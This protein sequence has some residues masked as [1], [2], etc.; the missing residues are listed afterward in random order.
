MDSSPSPECKDKDDYINDSTQRPPFNQYH[1]YNFGEATGNTVGTTIQAILLLL[2][3]ILVWLSGILAWDWELGQLSKHPG[4]LL[5]V[6]LIR[7]H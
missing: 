4:K 7:A 2:S 1:V 5:L 3:V 6:I